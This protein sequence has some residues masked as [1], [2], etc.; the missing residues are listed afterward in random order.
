MEAKRG[1]IVFP[2]EIF[3]CYREVEYEK[4]WSVH[5]IYQHGMMWV[6]PRLM[7]ER[8]GSREVEVVYVDTSLRNYN[9][10]RVIRVY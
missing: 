6:E 9:K 10:K 2:V 8:I 3:E 1:R 7:K 4:E 5:W